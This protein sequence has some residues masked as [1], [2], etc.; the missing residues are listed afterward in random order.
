MGK[1]RQK[2]RA[3]WIYSEHLKGA[4]KPAQTCP[5]IYSVDITFRG[6]FPWILQMEEIPGIKK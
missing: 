2:G 4:Q 1:I 6:H 5:E 3:D